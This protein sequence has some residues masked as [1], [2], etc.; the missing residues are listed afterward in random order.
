MRSRRV[1]RVLSGV[2]GAAVAAL[3]PV[4]AAVTGPSVNPDTVARKQV[5]VHLTTTSDPGGRHVVKGL[6]KQRPVRFRPG[7]G[8]NITVDESKTYQKFEGGGAAFTDT[9]GWLMNSSGTLSDATRDRAMT[10]LFDP[11]KGIG[12]S[13]LRNPMGASDLA[14][15]GYTYDDM[16]AGQHDPQLRHF[17]VEHD[18]ADILPLA[19]HARRLNPDIK[20]MASPWSAP[21]WMK[22]NGSLDQGRLQA[23]Y[24]GTYARYFVA[25][26]RAYKDRGVPV[27]YVTAQNEPNCCSG[28]PSMQWNAPGLA[29]FTKND[30]LPA[31]KKAGLSTKV[32]ALDWNWDR[33]R[34]LGAP[35]V[36]DAA[37][38]RHP[39][40]GGLAWHGY[41]GEVTE[42]T[43]VHNKYPGLATY[44]TEHSGGWWI[45]NQQREDMHNLIDYTRNWGRSWLKWSL[46]VDQNGG[47]HHGGCDGCTGLITVHHG[48]PKHGTVGYT[49]EYYTMGHLT[50]FVRPGARRIGSTD[51]ADV[52]NVAWKNPNG[53]KALI[54]YNDTGSTQKA[55]INW[56]GEHA[57]YDLP[58]GASAT[59]TWDG[60]PTGGDRNA[61]HGPV[62]A[63]LHREQE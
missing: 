20:V 25:Y 59:F 60:N 37:I 23:K 40:F 42:Q 16:P 9:A 17:S 32:L 13:F 10:K 2:A 38:R 62:T 30:L 26:L 4:W 3:V 19:A 41:S 24:Y 55:D 12:L 45:T 56:G 48:G 31:L 35:I 5:Q 36:D 39:N 52:P 7:G 18:L 6:E 21:A 49:V 44:D 43:R 54:V 53:S 63:A 29:Y 22:D 51:S 15:F 11:V 8:G 27:D 14:R 28:Y 46:A 1:R 57:S 58:A 47:P 33:Y 50:R 61:A 34:D